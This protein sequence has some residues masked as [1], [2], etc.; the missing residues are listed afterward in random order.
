M[1]F[2][3]KKG[4]TKVQSTAMQARPRSGTVADAIQPLCR[5]IFAIF[6]IAACALSTVD[7]STFRQIFYA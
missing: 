5:P 2:P 4:G 7:K 1:G 6:F 3:M